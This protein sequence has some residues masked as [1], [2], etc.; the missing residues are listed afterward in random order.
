MVKVNVHALSWKLLLKILEQ[1]DDFSAQAT[2]ASV[3]ALSE[4]EP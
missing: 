3:S 4:E 1:C 2:Q